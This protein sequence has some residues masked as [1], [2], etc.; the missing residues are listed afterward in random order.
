MCVFL[1]VIKIQCPHNA[2]KEIRKDNTR[3]IAGKEKM[4]AWENHGMIQTTD[5]QYHNHAREPNRKATAKYCPQI[6]NR[7]KPDHR[8][9]PRIF[10]TFSPNLSRHFFRKS[11]HYTE[12][13]HQRKSKTI[14][15][16]KQ[17]VTQLNLC[18][19]KGRG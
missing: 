3:K 19:Q 4:R 11:N 16:R 2:H 10:G 6:S 9:F 13:N 14:A 17:N 8:N 1:C 18:D 15:K 7:A 12:P 5:E